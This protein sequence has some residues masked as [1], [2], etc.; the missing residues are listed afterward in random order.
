MA[1][2]VISDNIFNG[3]AFI[4]G[5]IFAFGG[6]ML[7]AG[8]IVRLGQVGSFEPDQEFRFG[9]LEFVADSWGDLILTKYSALI[10]DPANP[11]ALISGEVSPATGADL[12]L[13]PA[14]CPDLADIPGLT[15]AEHSPNV[16]SNAS[17]RAILRI[18]PK[19]SEEMDPTDLSLLNEL[20]DWIQAM[21]ISNSQSSVY[22]QIGLK[23]DDREIYVPLSHTWSLPSRT[24]LKTIPHDHRS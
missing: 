15:S 5:Q 18:E 7:H 3:D 4:P 24:W 19:Y 21:G 11:E 17:G 14:L 23:S 20:L 8:P 6:I 2:L 10:E 9:N 22:D 16:T 12:A 1:C 13:D